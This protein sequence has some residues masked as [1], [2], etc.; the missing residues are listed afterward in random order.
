MTFDEV[1]RSP[2]PPAWTP[3]SRILHQVEA[4]AAEQRAVRSRNELL[5]LGPLATRR[6]A[7]MHELAAIERASRRCA[8]GFAPTSIGPGAAPATHAAEARR[9]EVQALAATVV[10]AD[11][12]FLLDL[13]ATLEGRR[14][15]VHDLDTGGATLA[16]YR[17][18]VV[19]DVA[20]AG[21]F[22]SR[23]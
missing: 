19:P 17:R 10:A 22:D 6:A 11:R 21:L 3:R 5:P 23:G 4:L 15:E 13:E 14:R 8:I 12:Q 9:A 20:S 16:A 1:A 18:I 7:L 2:T